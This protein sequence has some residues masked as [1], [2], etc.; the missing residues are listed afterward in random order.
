MMLAL[1]LGCSS[2]WSLTHADHEYL[3][4]AAAELAEAQQ[5]GD[6]AAA[7][8]A[9]LRMAAHYRARGLWSQVLDLADRARAELEGEAGTPQLQ[10]DIDLT[11]AAAVQEL[12]RVDEALQPMIRALATARRLDDADLEARA[13]VGLSS[14]QGRGGN[15]AAAQRLAEQALLAA[16]QAGNREWQARALLNQG[17]VAYQQSEHERALALV[18]QA[19]R[20]AP[21]AAA[22][23]LPQQ[24]LVAAAVA[25]EAVAA[26]PEVLQSA[27]A[28]VEQ[29]RAAGNAYLLAFGLEVQGKLQCELG[30]TAAAM[31]S[32]AEAAGLFDGDRHPYDSG[33]TQ[34]AWSDC[35]A[36]TGDYRGAWEHAQQ[37]RELTRQGMDQRRVESMEALDFA[38]RDKLR[39]REIADAAAEQRSL[40]AELQLQRALVIIVGL[41]LL[42]ALIAVLWLLS[43][44]RGA[45]AQARA[46]EA[47]Q[48]ARADLLAT[49]GHEIRNPSQGLVSALAALQDLPLDSQQ[50][51][52]MNTARHAAD[53][54]ARLSRDVFNLALAE[55]D[56]LVLHRRFVCPDALV[57]D[58]IS[59]VSAAAVAKGMEI[60]HHD[61]SAGRRIDIDA[62]RIMQ[63]LVNLLSN[64][65]RYTEKGRVRVDSRLI[66][67][68][69]PIWRCDVSDTGPGIP[70]AELEHVF[71]PYFRGEHGARVHGGGLGLAVVD[72]VIALHGG[73]IQVSNLPAGGARFRIEL[74]VRVIEAETDAAA[75]AKPDLPLARTRILLV[76]DDEDVRL[77]VA[78][79]AE[80]AGATVSLA[81]DASQAEAEFR[82]MLPDAVLVDLHLGNER[83]D[84]VAC[85]LK[86]I[87]PTLVC[88]WILATGSM[89]REDDIAGFDAVLIKPYTL[90]ELHA[91]VRG[92]IT[93]RVRA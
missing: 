7:S 66:D 84:E 82:K 60:D 26:S 75:P 90:A 8:A 24:L 42:M 72:R 79:M 51:Q 70:A 83:G 14:L 65:V 80:H 29:A 1:A 93:D 64:A 77:G 2:A 37:G 69:S 15:L 68:D 56:R 76:D 34:Y 35:L 18:Q 87:A 31:A 44:A 85:S 78:A 32:F 13:L 67:G 62:E 58:A 81:A 33:R 45:R 16:R 53:M 55:Q 23:D 39:A 38:Y 28:A 92:D 21:A 71:D 9:M 22:S 52:A 63:A 54:I 91:A 12:N 46:A 89:S 30:A 47:A 73:Q 36:R 59:L 43:R 88:R 49:A 57:R 20:V 25:A 11:F 48:Q 10:A 5:A 3:T 41:A 19:M 86:S 61:D 74:P 4:T 27:S 6:H 50:R 17:N 40:S